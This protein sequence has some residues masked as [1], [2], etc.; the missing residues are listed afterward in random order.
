MIRPSRPLPRVGGQVQIRHFG[1]SVEGGTIVAVHEDGARLDVEGEDGERYDFVLS[2][3]NARF[4]SA[5]D[6]HGPHL[7]IVAVEDLPDEHAPR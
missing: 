6:V 7:E 1:G 3:K 4:V 5:G 2:Q